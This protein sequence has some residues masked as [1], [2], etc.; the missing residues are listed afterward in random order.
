VIAVDAPDRDPAQLDADHL[1]RASLADDDPTGWFE[2]LYA[3][4]ETGEAVIPWDRDAP[5][6][7]LVEW[8]TERDLAGASARA[9]VVGSGPGHDAAYLALLGFATTGFDISETAVRTARRRYGDD[10]S[11]PAFVTGDLLDPAAEWLGAFDLVVEIMTVQALPDPPR[12]AAI[13]NVSRFVAAGGTLL[14]IAAA[15]QE[16]EPSGGPPWPLRRG[17]IDTF[18]AAGALEPVAV[19]HLVGPGTP[20]PHR[21][22][23][24]FHRPA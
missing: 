12:P 3:A 22:R 9:L 14:V 10:G 4:A 19:Q 1:S 2:P 15:F 18:A 17:E 24:E 20:P 21:W 6:P 5:H 23:A 11:G 13:A 8:A 7:L 16:G